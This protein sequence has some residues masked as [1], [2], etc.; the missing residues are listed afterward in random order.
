M[1]EITNYGKRCPNPQFERKDCFFLCGEW[2]FAFADGQSEPPAFDKKIIV[3]YSYECRASGIGDERVHECVWYERTFFLKEHAGRILLH[4]EAVD[5]Q[6]FVYVNGSFAGEHKGGF[7]HFCLDI[8]EI[9]K[10]GE[11]KLTVKVLDSLDKSQLRGKQRTKTENYDCWYVQTTGIW[12]P[13]WIEYAGSAY[14]QS[15]R[16]QAKCS[17]K[18]AAEFLLSEAEEMEFVVTDGE[19][20]DV[21]AARLPKQGKKVGYAFDIPSPK[22]WS[23]ENPH[24]YGVK[25]RVLGKTAD[26]VHTYFGIR[27]IEAREDGVYINGKR[28][29]QQMIL[30]QGYWKDTML[31]APGDEAIEKDVRAIR[32]MGFNGVRMHQ[33]VESFVFYSLCDKY[34]LYV[35]GEIP[36]AYAFDER[37]KGEFVR[38]CTDI[39]EQL[40]NHPCV[41]SWVLFNETWGVSDIKE[42]KEEQ[43]FVQRMYEEVR[44]ADD[45]PIITN[46]GWYHLGSDIL[47]LHEYEQDSETVAK[48]YADKAYVVANKKINA[49]FYGFA[50]ADGYRYGGQPV[51]ISEYGG[52]GVEGKEGWGYGDKAE[53]SREYETRLRKIV[54]S[55]M[56]IPYLT[57]CCYTQ[58]TDVQ[59]EVNGLLD[60]DR[61]PKLPIKTIREIFS[62]RK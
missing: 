25:I 13:V 10:T 24:L 8:T 12:K 23:G 39:V 44:K 31:T 52:I 27:E 32:E 42:N 41:V 29:F 17:G 15:C 55:V 60:A 50:F 33:K 38:D 36:S 61:R 11:N 30:D 62:R 16:F 54:D 37:M 9:A 18:V 40:K 34:G 5:Y 14:L 26:E 1:G 58:F 51:M 6:A 21:Y 47:S 35:W 59:Q 43:N 46:D 49:N 22:L 2:D 7:T 3:P 48:E 45:R 4:F 56:G 57:G 53:N 19:G 20:A 28:E